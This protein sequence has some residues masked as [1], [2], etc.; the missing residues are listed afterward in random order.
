VGRKIDE[1]TRKRRIQSFV[2]SLDYD[3]ANGNLPFEI[4]KFNANRPADKKIILKRKA[5][6]N[7]VK[8]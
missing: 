8:C 6:R 2:E 5:R 1:R 7:N 3:N 4:Q